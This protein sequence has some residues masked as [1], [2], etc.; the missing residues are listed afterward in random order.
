V[1]TNLN[2]VIKDVLVDF[3]EIID[4]K[5]ADVRIGKLPVIEAIPVQMTQLFHNLIG[6]ALKFS[7]EKPAPLIKIKSAT[8]A[9]EEMVKF[10]SFDKSKT[11]CQITVE[12]NG[13]G[14]EQK[15]AGKI[16]TI[17][18]RLEEKTKYPGNGIGL[19]LCRKIVDNHNGI[20]YTRSEENKGATFYIIL[21][22][23]RLEEE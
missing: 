21:P 2:V 16:F 4:R 8:L 22:V 18:Q 7:R 1:P 20:I 6:N 10:P 12:D 3:D 11:Y 13:I 23:K 15:F 9:K 19:A 14:F 5:K 17:F